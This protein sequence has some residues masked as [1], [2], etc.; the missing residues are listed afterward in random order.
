MEEIIVAPHSPDSAKL[1]GVIDIMTRLGPPTL[2]VYW[3][4]EKYHAL[5][6]SHRLAAAECLGL[7]VRV[8]TT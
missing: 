8:L 4:G 5:E 3:D 7:P 6:G 2:D 1:N